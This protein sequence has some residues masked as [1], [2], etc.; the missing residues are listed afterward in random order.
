MIGWKDCTIEAIGVRYP[1]GLIALP[2]VEGEKKRRAEAMLLIL[3]DR[4][5]VEKLTTEKFLQ[6]TGDD[7]KV[8]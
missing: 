3:G 4:R 6:T 2:L 8:L 7:N 5:G 1:M